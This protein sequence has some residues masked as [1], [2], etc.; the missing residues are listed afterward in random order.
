MAI[1]LTEFEEKFDNKVAKNM[2]DNTKN[3]TKL[4][5]LTCLKE[6]EFLHLIDRSQYCHDYYIF[7]KLV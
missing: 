4:K 2:V 7:P 5:T 6:L 1:K 3:N